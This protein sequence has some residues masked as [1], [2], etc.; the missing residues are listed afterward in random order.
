[1]R[2]LRDALKV[3][4]TGRMQGMTTLPATDSSLLVRTDFTAGAAWQSLCAAVATENED[5]FLAYVEIVDD[6]NL[7]GT[8][9]AEL[10]ATILSGDANAAVLFIADA[11]T[12][13]AP[14][15]PILVVDLWDE[16]PTFRCIASE[17]WAVDNNLNLGNMDW[18]DFS[19]SVDSEGVYRGF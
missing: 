15:F 11:T 8:P 9:P 10:R 18:E 17:L 4:R 2:D 12:L 16:H 7:G 5:G 6:A 14:D 19:G 3:P 1:M 13:A